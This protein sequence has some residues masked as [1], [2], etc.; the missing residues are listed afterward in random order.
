MIND[1]NY[2]GYLMRYADGELN[3]VEAAKVMS[4]LDS[5]PEIRKELEAITDPSLIIVPPLATMP[6]KEK[7]LKPVAATTLHAS[8][9]LW[10]GIAAATCLLLAFGIVLRIGR[11]S[12][13]AVTAYNHGEMPVPVAD[14]PLPDSLYI[15]RGKPAPVN[16]AKLST[17]ANSRDNVAET[18]CREH[19]IVA[20][21]TLA[22]PFNHEPAPLL[23]ENNSKQ[24]ITGE[25]PLLPNQAIR[26]SSN[27]AIK[28]SN[29]LI[30][31]A[32]R[33]S[34]NQAIKQSNNLIVIET[35]QLVT[36]TPNP[37]ERNDIRV[38]S[39]IENNNIALAEQKGLLGRAFDA[40]SRFILHRNDDENLY[41]LA[42]SE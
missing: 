1:E 36:L 40:I 5:H 29:N 27:Q 28:Q 4:F 9:Q 2:E 3:A 37:Q 25:P 6:G 41:N 22:I 7:L 31:Q 35:D 32:I 30:N 24:A 10:L 11:H 20:T 39:V 33:Q 19:S 42:F 12:E 38:C 15:G 23:A 34:S 18:E 21:D 13:N 16:L 17:T 8:R 26:Q 14:T